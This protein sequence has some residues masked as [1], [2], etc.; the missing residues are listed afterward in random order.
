ML[1]YISNWI[2]EILHIE[3]RVR[4]HNFIRISRLKFRRKFY[5][6]LRRIQNLSV[7]RLIMKA[8]TK[9]CFIGIW[10]ENLIKYIRYKSLG[11]NTLFLIEKNV[12]EGILLVGKLLELISVE[13]S[14]ISNLLGSTQ[15]FFG[16]L[17]ATLPARTHADTLTHTP[18]QPHTHSHPHTHTHTYTAT[19]ALRQTDPVTQRLRDTHR[20]SHTQTYT[21]RQTDTHT[22]P[23]TNRVYLNLNGKACDY[24]MVPEE[25]VSVCMS[26]FGCVS[27]CV[28]VCLSVCGCGCVWLW[29]WVSVCLSLCVS[30]S[31]SMSISAACDLH[32]I[33]LVWHTR[34]SDQSCPQM[35]KTRCKFEQGSYHKKFHTS[36]FVC[37]CW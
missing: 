12:L 13:W 19:E 34:Q 20:Q 23:H 22:H 6:K 9:R 2:V 33:V 16:V 37:K 21:L 36:F 8:W 1:C 10:H 14:R 27:D 25:S 15:L 31:V 17:H 3:E 29:Q 32:I 24:H 7:V 35:P 5:Q 26:I 4:M 28:S 11:R 18:T 30:V